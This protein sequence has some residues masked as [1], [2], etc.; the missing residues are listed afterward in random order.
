MKLTQ[1]FYFEAAHTLKREY[2]KNSDRIHGHT[3]V[4]YVS[5]EGIPKENG[6][7][8]DLAFLK[9]NCEAVKNMLDHQFLDNVPNLG[10]PTLENLCI[11]IS[12]NLNN[13][14]ICEIIVERAIS[15]DKCTY[16]FS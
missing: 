4:A 16:V 9:E 7:I 1:S 2:E 3:Y 5:I 15:G 6:M 10:L 13:L 8:V 12:K 14:P 11:F